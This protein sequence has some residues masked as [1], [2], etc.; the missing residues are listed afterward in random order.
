MNI[1]N[2]NGQLI[3]SINIED[4]QQRFDIDLGNVPRGIYLLQFT[5]TNNQILETKRIVIH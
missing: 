5:K 4:G 2:T 1:V 3:E